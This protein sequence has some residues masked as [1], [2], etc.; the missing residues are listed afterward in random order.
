MLG[1]LLEWCYFATIADE[2]LDLYTSRAPQVCY[3]EFKLD[4]EKQLLTYPGRRH[5]ANHNTSPAFQCQIEGCKKPFQRADLLT[6]HM[7]RQ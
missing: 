6:R 7:E 2:I 1:R 3:D 5:E 4:I